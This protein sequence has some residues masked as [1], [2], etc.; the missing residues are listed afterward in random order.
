MAL[1]CLQEPEPVQILGPGEMVLGIVKVELRGN[2][3]ISTGHVIMGIVQVGI[4]LVLYS[5]DIVIYM[6]N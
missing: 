6:W 3:I 4:K 2:Q 5:H 1:G